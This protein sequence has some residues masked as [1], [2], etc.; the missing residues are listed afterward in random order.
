MFTTSRFL[1]DTPS[2]HMGRDKVAPRDFYIR[3][4]GAIPATYNNVLIPRP[5]IWDTDFPIVLPTAD[6]IGKILH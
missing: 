2:L 6:K 4:L 3:R 5:T 1:L